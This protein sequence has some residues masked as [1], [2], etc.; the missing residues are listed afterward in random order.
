[1]AATPTSSDFG[2]KNGWTAPMS[3]NISVHQ[4]KETLNDTETACM[5]NIFSKTFCPQFS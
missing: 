2:E 5:D 4:E 3:L 1:M